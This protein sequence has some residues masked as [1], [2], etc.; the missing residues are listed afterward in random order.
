MVLIQKVPPLL[1]SWLLSLLTC[2]SW[3]TVASPSLSSSPNRNTMAP[4]G[5]VSCPGPRA[6][7]GI[8]MRMYRESLTEVRRGHVEALLLKGVVGR[9][10]IRVVVLTELPPPWARRNRVSVGRQRERERRERPP[11]RTSATPAVVLLTCSLRGSKPPK[12]SLGITE[13]ITCHET[14]RTSHHCSIVGHV[15]PH[16]YQRDGATGG[17]LAWYRGTAFIT[18]TRPP[19]F[20]L[21]RKSLCCSWSTSC[22][23][24]RNTMSSGTSRGARTS[25]LCGDTAK[26]MR[27]WMDWCT[28]S[29]V[30]F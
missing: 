21:P 16:C 4:P 17:A 29:E 10:C 15:I 5:M 30:S 6:M 2:P 7:Y 25:S 12:S 28:H 20:A 9:R 13:E 22:F 26:P 8:R 11:T 19:T 3:M 24:G 27:V 18:G 14:R 23:L 1:V